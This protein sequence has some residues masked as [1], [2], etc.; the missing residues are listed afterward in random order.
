M[1]ACSI[2]YRFSPLP[3]TRARKPRRCRELGVDAAPV[4]RL[5]RLQNLAV[6]NGNRIA[7]AVAQRL[8]DAVHTWRR[9]HADRLGDSVFVRRLGQSVETFDDGCTLCALNADKM[10]EPPNLGKALVESE[11]ERAV[12]DRDKDIVGHNVTELVINFVRH[13]LDSV[14][15]EGVV[16]VRCIVVAAQFRAQDAARVH[17][18][19]RHAHHLRAVRRDL[20]CTLGGN[21]IGHVDPARN[22]CRR[23]ICRDCR[24]RIAR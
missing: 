4:Q 19:V 2:G 1:I 15:K 22:A 12:P 18:P 6:L 9:T 3:G 17:A 11:E 16:D 24:T 20:L 23:R 7:A 5:C 21:I 10:R 14:G 8:E 13:T